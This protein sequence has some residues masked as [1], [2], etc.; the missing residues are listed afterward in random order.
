M[1]KETIEIN[2]ITKITNFI[3]D[4]SDFLIGGC[5][6]VGWHIA[7]EFVDIVPMVGSVGDDPFQQP[8]VSVHTVVVLLEYSEAIA[9]RDGQGRVADRLKCIHGYAHL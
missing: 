5:H 6:I 9:L 3:K 2:R 4:I 1:K 7:N 8:P